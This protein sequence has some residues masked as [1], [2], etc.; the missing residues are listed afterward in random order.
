MQVIS[1]FSGS[2]FIQWQK[3][4]LIPNLARGQPY[5]FWADVYDIF[6]GFL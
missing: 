4:E 5:T 3:G 2:T 1:T 6:F